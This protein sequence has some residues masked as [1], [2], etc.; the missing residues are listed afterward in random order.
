MVAIAR[1]SA[2]T[3]FIEPSATRDGPSRISSSVP[4]VP[5][6]TR[7][8]RGSSA[9]C[10]SDAPVAA[11]AGRL[12]RAGQRRADHHR[13]GAAGDRLGDVA[14]AAHAAVGDDVHVAAAGLVHVVAAG[15]G[16]VGDRGGH[17]HRDAEHVARGVRGAA[18][19]ADEHARR[20]GAH[21]VQRRR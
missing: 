19:E 20:A 16:D 10:A 11:A 5:T 17:R 21:Q 12:G 6:S 8:P 2:P 3:R 4:T 15:R 7:S 14:G 13:V 9:W 1:R 18:A